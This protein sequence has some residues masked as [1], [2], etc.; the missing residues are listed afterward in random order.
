MFQV[1]AGGSY[2]LDDNTH[3]YNGGHCTITAISNILKYWKSVCCPRYPSNYEDI[4]SVVMQKAIELGYFS[5]TRNGRGMNILEA[6]TVIDAVNDSYNYNGVVHYYNENQLTLSEIKAFINA[7]WPIYFRM[8]TTPGT[9]TYQ[10]H[11]VVLFGYNTVG[12]Y[13]NGNFEQYDF[14]KLYDGHSIRG[15][16]YVC[17]DM[18]NYYAAGMPF[19]EP[20]N[21]GNPID[22][23]MDFAMFAFCPY[24]P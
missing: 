24:T 19:E 16:C 15:K 1:P 10:A 6:K 23:E 3:V 4:F 20:D 9:F 18:L 21:N 11:A 8:G 13:I 5:N 17:F 12:G 22:C 2:I 14:I 7:D